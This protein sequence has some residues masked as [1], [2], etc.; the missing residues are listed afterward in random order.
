[1]AILP[2]LDEIKL[3]D[4][5]PTLVILERAADRLPQDF[6]DWWNRQD[7]QNRVLVL[8]ADPNAVKTLRDG[9][10]RMRAIEK[11]E[12]R[13]KAQH[14]PASPQ[15]QELQGV[16]GRETAGFTS[17]LRE[18]FK[19]IV[20]P[21]GKALRKV[22]DFR[23]EFE[24]NDY[25]GE[26]QI[27][28]TLTKRGKFIPSDK[29]DEQ[30][31]TLCLDAQEILFD[32]DAVQQSS[33][34][35]NA[36]VRS[37]WFWLPRNGLDQLV[38]L[39]VQR[40]FWRERE[41]LIAKKWER[42]TKVTARLDDFGPNPI[43]TGRFHINVTPE[44]ADTVYVSESGPPIPASSG[45]LDGRVY[46]TAA[47]AAWFLAVDSKGSA[48]TGDPCEWRAPIRVKPDVKRVSGGYRVSFIA[49]PRAAKIRATFDGSDPK[50]G[51]VISGADIEAPP[52]ATRLRAVGEV[53]GQFGEEESAP[54]QTGVSEAGGTYTVNRPA[55]KLDSP[56]TLTSRFEPKDTAKAFSALD[57]LAK[58]AG[59]RILGGSVEVN[60]GRSEQDFLTLRLGRDVPILAGDLDG[61]VK[62]LVEKL[63]AAAPTV[64]LRLD[65]IE[66]S[67]GREL[68]A[69]CDDMGVDF[70]R[71]TWDQKP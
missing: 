56:A 18:T 60:G 16:K 67:S 43:E 14:G 21:T 58:A 1:M 66:F 62:T 26:Q 5:R 69:F 46:E 23:M 55:L 51:P 37:G 64:K 57:R 33:L 54:L 27:I 11:V 71:V 39:A 7:L 68:T 22:D 59:A 10:R 40:G 30:F 2:A 50:L 15:M 4:D 53:D 28:D 12:E 9:A 61:F 19:T 49:S 6:V 25:S 52:A 47:P 32:A 41:G 38:K 29:F 35:R 31:E 8:T 34:R 70:D 42:R 36:A 3:D 24:R 65:G 45:K 13:I 20:F 44:D 48:K 63:S 17:A